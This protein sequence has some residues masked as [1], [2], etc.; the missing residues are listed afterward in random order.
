M[1]SFE[2]ELRGLVLGQVVTICTY[3]VSGTAIAMLKTNWIKV[4]PLFT[5]TTTVYIFLLE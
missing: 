4:W 3:W 2:T 5:G 1:L